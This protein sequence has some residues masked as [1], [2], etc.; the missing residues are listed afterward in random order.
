[1]FHA[2]TLGRPGL[3]EILVKRIFIL[4][5]RVKSTVRWFGFFQ[6]CCSLFLIEFCK[7]I[8]WKCNL[9]P[10]NRGKK[11]TFM[12]QKLLY[13]WWMHKI[14]FHKL[15]EISINCQKYI[16]KYPRAIILG[17]YPIFNDSFYLW[18]ILGINFTLVSNTTT[19][20]PQVANFTCNNT[21]I[22]RV[23]IF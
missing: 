15:P 14:N 17:T 19:E 23:G 8:G 7:F 13:H 6:N 20:T 5:A 3:C 4:C 10:Q 12:S 9:Y 18:T 21:I 1:M 22:S 16:Y 11:D 2:P